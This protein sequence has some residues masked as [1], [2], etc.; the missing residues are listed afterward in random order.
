MDRDRRRVISALI[1]HH[2]IVSTVIRHCFHSYRISCIFVYRIFLGASMHHRIIRNTSYRKSCLFS[3]CKSNILHTHTHARTQLIQNISIAKS[4]YL[5]SVERHLN[6]RAIYVKIYGKYLM[7]L[8]VSLFFTK[9]DGPVG[10]APGFY[11]IWEVLVLSL[12]KL[13]LGSSR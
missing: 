13:C 12:L 4:R 8:F 10:F 9:V 5:N 11:S 3:E 2:D 1:R 7:V 6:I